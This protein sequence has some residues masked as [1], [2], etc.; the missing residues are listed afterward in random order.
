MFNISITLCGGSEKIIL[1]D[2]SKEA[3]DGLVKSI[4]SLKKGALKF[5]KFGDVYI[6]IDTIIA[7]E[8][9]KVQ[10]R[11]TTGVPSRR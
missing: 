2:V 8:C 6:R 3:F 11:I 4:N 10:K 1:K 5:E 9:I 7:V